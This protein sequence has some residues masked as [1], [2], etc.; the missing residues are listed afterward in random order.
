LRAAFDS[1]T[2]NLI[3]NTARAVFIEN[4]GDK[5]IRDVVKA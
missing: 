2:T 5:D 3:G 1:A 4:K